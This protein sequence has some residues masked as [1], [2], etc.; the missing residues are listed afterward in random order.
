M[1]ADST[2]HPSTHLLNSLG[3]SM[4]YARALLTGIS[5]EQFAHMPMPGFNHPAFC[6][7]HLACYP[8]RMMELL[9][10]PEE[11]CELPFDPAPY[12]AG[13][14]CVEQDGRYAA[15]PVIVDAFF[16]GYERVAQVLPNVPPEVFVKSTELDG[17][18]G[19]LFPRIG[20]A[21]DFMSG[22]HVM[23]HLGQVSMW[24]RAIGLGPCM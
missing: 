6:Y 4:N 11:Q 3:F 1:P 10:C 9:G 12:K 7:G 19:E 5:E 23:L 15:M 20:D 16:T 17:R 14:E 22:N 8:N 21:I 2:V 24:R 18:M 13:A